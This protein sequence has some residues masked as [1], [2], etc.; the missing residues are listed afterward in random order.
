MQAVVQVVAQANKPASRAGQAI[1]AHFIL[2]QEFQAFRC[3]RAGGIL[4]LP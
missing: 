1:Q 2:R 3:P 4:L